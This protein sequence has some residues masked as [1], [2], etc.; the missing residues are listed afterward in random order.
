[1]GIQVTIYNDDHHG[2]VFQV[3]KLNNRTPVAHEHHVV[4]PSEPGHDDA[5]PLCI[6]ISQDEILIIAPAEA[7]GDEPGDEKDDS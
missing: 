3:T 2:R 5:G 7:V 6:E 1:M 4:K